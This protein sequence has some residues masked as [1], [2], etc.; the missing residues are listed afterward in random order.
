M[1]VSDQLV[2]KRGADLLWRRVSGWLRQKAHEMRRERWAYVFVAPAVI[3]FLAFRI[4]PALRAVQFSFM[5]VTP[6][7]MQWIGLDNFRD[8]VQDSLFWD[9]IG[10]SFT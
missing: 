7:A 10:I 6:Q 8:L 9:S 3:I 2:P 1:A 4:Y 5:R